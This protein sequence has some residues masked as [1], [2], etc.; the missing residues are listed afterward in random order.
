MKIFQAASTI[1]LTTAA[2]LALG[3]PASAE[4]TQSDLVVIGQPATARSIQSE[5]NAPDRRFSSNRHEADALLAGE[6]G[7]WSNAVLLAAKAYREND[8][9]SNEFNLANGYQNTG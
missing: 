5:L 4:S 2:L 6:K 3:Q 9:L 7:D 8:S 1:I